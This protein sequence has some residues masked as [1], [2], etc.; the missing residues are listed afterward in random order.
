MKKQIIIMLSVALAGTT[1][2]AGPTNSGGRKAADPSRIGK[3]GGGRV[4][5]STELAKALESAGMDSKLAE[6]YAE[7]GLT[8]K[9]DVIRKLNAE[10]SSSQKQAVT[11]VMEACVSTAVNAKSLSG[12]I[13]KNGEALAK[14]AETMSTK[15]LETVLNDNNG[16]MDL[17][18]VEQVATLLSLS[19]EDLANDATAQL[20]IVEV[21]SALGNG[22]KIKD[23]ADCF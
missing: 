14:A 12:S 19:K 20:K 16:A 10:L 6:R 17:T 8:L 9:S 21:E 23:L 7:A 4:E 2:F 11:K 18:K 15:V 1:V 22:R 5:K 3:T 13:S